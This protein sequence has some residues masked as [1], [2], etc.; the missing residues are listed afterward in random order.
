MV[1]KG[2][3]LTGAQLRAA[4]ALLNLSAEALAEE[5]KIGLRT[6]GRAEQENGPVRITAANAERLIS[7]LEERGVEFLSR[8]GV[9]A[10][11]RVRSKP[12]PKFGK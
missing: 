8:E 12:P 10:G 6:I 11:V 9:G 7:A 2:H 5:T 1:K 4:R 3:V